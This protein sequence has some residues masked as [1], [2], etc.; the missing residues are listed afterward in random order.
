MNNY[1]NP[2]VAVYS[3]EF[4][5]KKFIIRNHTGLEEHIEYSV[6]EM[7]PL[8]TSWTIIGHLEFEGS[9]LT[10]ELMN[11][12]G[13]RM[14]ENGRS[15]WAI[16]YEVPGTPNAGA[17]MTDG[18]YLAEAYYTPLMD[19]LPCLM[20]FPPQRWRF[21]GT[22]T[23]H[24]PVDRRAHSEYLYN[25]QI[26]RH[27]WELTPIK[28]LPGRV[29]FFTTAAVLNTQTWDLTFLVYDATTLGRSYVYEAAT[30]LAGKRVW[31]KYAQAEEL[32]DPFDLLLFHLDGVNYVQ[33][34]PARL[35]P[36]DWAWHTFIN[37]I[38]YTFI[39]PTDRCKI[40]EKDSSPF[41]VS[42]P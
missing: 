1:S 34:V 6:P 28:D 32:M 25:K 31:V 12:V 8:D 38:R 35:K 18:F 9:P 37:T 41:T 36:D 29:D 30:K 23:W 3:E 2:S 21:R 26:K 4:R 39:V 10:D 22:K 14:R 15:E 40:A 19:I 7:I 24:N 27:D 16:G 17:Y 11:V 13:Y 5:G 42:L 33:V 20:D